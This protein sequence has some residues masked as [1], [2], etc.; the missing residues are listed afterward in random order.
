MKFRRKTAARLVASS[1]DESAVVA[2][3]LD[4]ISNWMTQIEDAGQLTKD[5]PFPRLYILAGQIAQDNI[6]HERILFALIHRREVLTRKATEGEDVD[7]Y[8]D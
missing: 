8:A 3:R 4:V 5:T 2:R 7:D 6:E 1:D